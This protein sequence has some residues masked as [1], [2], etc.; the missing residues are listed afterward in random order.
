MSRRPRTPTVPGTAS[1]FS[2][3][4]TSQARGQDDR[5]DDGQRQRAVGAAS[6][7]S[8]HP[9]RRK[10]S[11]RRDTNRRRRRRRRRPSARR[12]GFVSRTS[13]TG[14][15]PERSHAT[16]DTARSATR[17]RDRGGRFASRVFVSRAD[18]PRSLAFRG[19]EDEDAL[20]EEPQN[21]PG[22]ARAAARAR[23]RRAPVERSIPRCSR[24][25]GPPAAPSFAK[26]FGASRAP[27]SRQL[28]FRRGRPPRRCRPTG[29][30]RSF[31]ERSG[32]TPLRA[33]A[34]RRHRSGGVGGPAGFA[35]PGGE[36]LSSASA[37]SAAASSSTRALRAPT[38]RGAELLRAN[39]RNRSSRRRTRLGATQRRARRRGARR[40]RRL[41][42]PAIPREPRRGETG[43]RVVAD[44]FERRASRA[45]RRAARRALRGA[46]DAVF[47]H[48]NVVADD[49]RVIV[50]QRARGVARARPRATTRRLRVLE[51]DVERATRSRTASAPLPAKAPARPRGLAPARRTPPPPRRPTP[52]PRV[53]TK[54][55]SPPVRGASNSAATSGFFFRKAHRSLTGPSIFVET[56]T[57]R[58]QAACHAAW[59][60]PRALP[61]HRAE[62]RL[63]PLP[64]RA[65]SSAR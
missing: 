9:F 56:T 17:A 47:V 8:D 60:G 33:R 62:Q 53:A 1:G 44:G 45:W 4:A 64:A 36:A 3:A 29:V 15:G 48:G 40:T 10:S 21:E 24:R 37:S 41:E 31:L 63:H 5:A 30:P 46:L 52:C 61:R 51:R 19:P 35:A 65:P 22:G 26:S 55:A 2:S 23:P 49:R 50:Q 16:R 59:D 14:S 12:A 34:A 43:H 32:R 6:R 57:R 20:R 27:P 7:V 42:R 58:S 38:T 28:R 39:V 11:D 18:S 54:S 25:R 13:V